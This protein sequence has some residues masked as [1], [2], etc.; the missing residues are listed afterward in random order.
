[1]VLIKLLIAHLI[2]DFFLQP[3]SWVEEKETSKL[4]SPKLYIHVAVHIALMFL[5]LLTYRTGD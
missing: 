1:M 2:G 4:K 5:L 3:K